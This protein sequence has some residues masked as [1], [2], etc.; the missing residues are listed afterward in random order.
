MTNLRSALQPHL[1]ADADFAGCTETQRST[2]GYHFAIRGLNICFPIT[3]ISKRQTGVSHSTPEAEIVSA[4]S[5]IRHCGLPSFALWWTL[6]PQK[7]KLMFH[8]DNHAMIRVAETGRNPTTRYLAGTHRVSVAWLRETFSQQNISLM[9]EVSSRMCA[10]IY[11]K[12][13]TEATQW[14]AVCD[15]ISIVGPKRLQQFL[16]DFW[17]RQRQRRQRR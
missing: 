10:D 9:H 1:F 4:G 16:A 5:S 13:F 6:L 3:G 11:T 14:Q 2:S 17:H 7:P 15:L 8:E 12:A